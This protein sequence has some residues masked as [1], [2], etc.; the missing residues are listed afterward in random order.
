[1][2]PGM[3]GIQQRYAIKLRQLVAEH[4]L[5]VVYRPS[6]FDDVEIVS[7][8]IQRPSLQLAGFYD[9]FDVD[10]VRLWGKSESAFLD[11]LPDDIHLRAIDDLFS[12][13]SRW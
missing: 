3:H 12:K 2:E 10:R 1:M 7:Y 6:N 4:D 8:N 13:R 5:E 9:Y 11:T